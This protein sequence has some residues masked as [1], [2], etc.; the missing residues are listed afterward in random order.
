MNI[1][2]DCLFMSEE[3]SP[4]TGGLVGCSRTLL[5]LLLSGL[6]SRPP[7]VSVHESLSVRRQCSSS[8]LH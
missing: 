7:S 2:V 8:I 6:E 3:K 5:S 4:R 1:S